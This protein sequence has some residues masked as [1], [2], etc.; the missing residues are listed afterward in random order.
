MIKHPHSRAERLRLKYLKETF[1][2]K[3]KRSAIRHRKQE[4]EAKELEDELRITVSGSQEEAG[5]P[6]NQVRDIPG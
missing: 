1:D 5:I 6:T 3:S 2:N 4:I